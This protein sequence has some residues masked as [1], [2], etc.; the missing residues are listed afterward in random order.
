M[1]GS[2][3]KT[4]F[5]LALSQLEAYLFRPNVDLKL[6]AH[7]FDNATKLAIPPPRISHIGQGGGIL[8]YL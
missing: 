3:L 2:R 6:F 7:H 4:L 5:D 8:L 1:F